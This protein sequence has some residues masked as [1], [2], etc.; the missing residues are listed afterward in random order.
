MLKKALEGEPK[1]RFKQCYRAIFVDLAESWSE[2][3]SL[4]VELREKL[5][6]VCPISIRAEMKEDAGGSEKAL[7]TLADGLAIETVL[8]AHEDGRNTVC[9]SSQVGC[10]MGC[11]FCATGRIGF[12]RNLTRDEIVEQVLLFARRLKL[13]GDKVTNVV[14]MGMGEPFLNYDNVM[15]AIKFLNDP[16][17]INLGARRFSISTA[18]V[19]HGIKKL[20]AEKLEVNLAFSLHAADEATRSKIM[21][22]NKKFPLPAVLKEINKYTEKTRRRVMFE[23]VMID[24][25]NDSP[26]QAEELARLLKG[27][28][29]FVN[30]ISYNRTDMFRPSSAESIRRFKQVLEKNRLP[31]VERHRF[32]ESIEAACG[33]LS[34]R[35]N[36]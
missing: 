18:G 26:K 12:K 8:I 7:I 2:A 25:I 14:F 27:Y 15:A 11:L 23:Y 19:T 21:P 22:I 5:E 6:E 33:Q 10:P 36:R 9:V 31:A 16:D 30:L 20:A 29:G 1:Y 32:G 17:T 4:P 35:K 24:G 3:S 34:A 13:S 28:L